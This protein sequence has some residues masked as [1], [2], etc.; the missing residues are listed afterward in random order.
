[1]IVPAIVTG[2]FGVPAG[3]GAK[4]Q[5]GCHP[6]YRGACIPISASDVDC[7]GGTGNGPYYVGRVVV[8][9]P[10]VFDLDRD[11]DGIGCD[12]APRVPPGGSILA[13]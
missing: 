11:N 1:M 13:E 3:I 8:V 2:F 5:V 10:D 6:S 4:A 12:D 7:Y 9:G